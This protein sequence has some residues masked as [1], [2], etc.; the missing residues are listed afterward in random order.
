[1]E[2]IAVQGEQWKGIVRIVELFKRA[3]IGV[4]SEERN[5]LLHSF[6]GDKPVL[7]GFV[8]KVLLRYT[9]VSI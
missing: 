8:R 2:R 5:R 1:M 3:G 7:V 9:Q 6:T 4:E